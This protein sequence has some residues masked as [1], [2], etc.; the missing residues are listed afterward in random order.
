MER[1]PL[2]QRI[3]AY[4]EAERPRR[5]FLDPITQFRY[6][7]RDPFQFRRQVLSFVRFLTDAGATVLFTSESSPEAPDDDLQ[8]LSDAIILL[9]HQAGSRSLTVTKLRGSGF[10]GGPHAVRLDEHGLKVFPRLVPAEHGAAF[11]LDLLPF[12]IPELDQMLRGGLERGTVTIISGPSG[13]GKSTLGMQFIVSAAARG[14]RSL[15][16]AFEEDP[17]LIVH[18]AENLGMRCR[19][20]MQR[21]LLKIVLVEPL[22]YSADEFAHMVRQDVE[23]GEARIVMIDSIS[24]YRLALRGEDLP[25]HLH[26]LAKYLQRMG[27][28]VLLVNETEHVTG[29]FRA[30]EAG[31][32][33]VADN[34]IFLRYLELQGELRRLIGVLKKRVSGC[35]NTLRELIIEAGGIRVGEPLRGL[36]GVL[37]GVPE[38]SA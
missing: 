16:Y 3:V 9:E 4:V 26:A 28:A 13:T 23:Q 30:T 27:A 6:L 33:F 14:E 21:G 10:R 24:G 17:A 7:T 18:R 2:T 11:T 5:V 34:L 31:I 22:R 20:L 19:A 8:F 32:S 12:G 1:T 36:R 15:L 35:E 38:A 29:A 25:G 37:Q